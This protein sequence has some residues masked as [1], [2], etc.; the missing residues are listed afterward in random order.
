VNATVHDDEGVNVMAYNRCIG[1]RY[2]ANNCPYKVRRF[3]YFDYNKRSLDELYLGPLANQSEMPELVKLVKN[4][5]VSVR[6]RGVME[7]CT[8]CVQRVQQAKIAQKRI[9]GASDNVLVPDGTIKTA[10][11]QVC[12]AE[13]IVFGNIKDE[14]SAVSKAKAQKRDY[15]VLGYLNVRPRTTYLGKLRN[16]ND[17]MPDY[18]NLPLS[19]IEY[20]SKNHPASHGEAAHGES[21][22]HGHENG[23]SGAAHGEHSHAPAGEKPKSEHGGHN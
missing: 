5:D 21:H 16:P 7:K 1:T 15:A 14:H 17:K 18:Q 2:C 13:A 23:A 12:P 8:Y 4:P 20:N 9:A 11:Q 6:M 22:G 3:N 10:C 19:R